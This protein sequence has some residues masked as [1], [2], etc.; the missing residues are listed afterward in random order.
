MKMPFHLPGRRPAGVVSASERKAAPAM[1]SALQISGEARWTGRS[2]AS[3]SREGFMKNPVAHRAIR[4]IAEASA[5]MPWQLFEDGTLIADHPLLS[6]LKRPNGRMSGSDFFEALYGHLLLSGNAYVEPAPPVADPFPWR[7]AIH[8]GLCTLRLSPEV[9]WALSPMEFAAMA[10][11][12]SPAEA[13]PS[14]A[15]LDE[16][17]IRFPDS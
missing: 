7:A 2:Y 6:L 3:L 16:L 1:I 14:R 4:L 5:A 15:T 10:G 8:T 13:Y 9:F 12:L 11:A 17:L